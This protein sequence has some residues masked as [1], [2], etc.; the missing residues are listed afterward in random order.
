[1]IEDDGAKAA[2]PGLRQALYE[3]GRALA[4][5]VDAERTLN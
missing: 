1:M 3:V 5:K 2:L 4:R